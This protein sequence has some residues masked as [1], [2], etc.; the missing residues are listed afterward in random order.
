[1]IK[2]ER[3]STINNINLAKTGDIKS[4]DLEVFDSLFSESPV[5]FLL[6]GAIPESDM[7]PFHRVK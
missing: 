2:Q 4:S 5:S 3:N 1:M 7:P 6:R